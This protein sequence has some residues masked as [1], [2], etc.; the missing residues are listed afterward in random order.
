MSVCRLLSLPPTHSTR[1]PISP[2]LPRTLLSCSSFITAL[3]SPALI[4]P[5]DPTLML[6]GTKDSRVTGGMEGRVV[7]E[8]GVWGTKACD[9]APDGW[10]TE[11]GEGA[12][13]N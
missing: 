1:P 4:R 11:L 13:D 6:S 7:W 10:M 9:D 3:L 5:S 8:G 2:I 12:R